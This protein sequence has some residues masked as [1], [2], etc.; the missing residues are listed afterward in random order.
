MADVI[1]RNSYKPGQLLQ[2]PAGMN[3][4][5][6][7]DRPAKYRIVG[8]TDSFGSELIDWCEECYQEYK[9][10]KSQ[11]P[12]EKYCEYCKTE[13]KHVEKRRDPSEGSCGPVYDMCGDC[14]N[15]II[16]DFLED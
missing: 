8:E 5:E 16:D 12:E 6:H 14:Y 4:D 3:C 15:R 9:Q 11:E 13:K 10:Q 1:G 7:E 2:V